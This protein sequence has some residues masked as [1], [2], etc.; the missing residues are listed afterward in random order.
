MTENM[1][2]GS[3][4]A[5]RTNTKHLGVAGSVQSVAS[6]TDTHSFSDAMDGQLSQKCSAQKRVRREITY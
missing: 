2:I 3:S 4:E 1:Q 5:D 6:I